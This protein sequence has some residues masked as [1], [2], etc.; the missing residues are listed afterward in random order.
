MRNFIVQ[1]KACS[2]VVPSRKAR[3]QDHDDLG[4]PSGK[5]TKARLR[6]KLFNQAINF[7]LFSRHGLSVM[8][9]G[10]FQPAFQLI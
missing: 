5:T 4:T 2:V 6:I 7:F 3:A 10:S 9:L 8:A 1:T